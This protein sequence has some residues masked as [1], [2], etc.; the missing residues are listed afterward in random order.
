M[1]SPEFGWYH[2][3]GAREIFRGAASGTAGRADNRDADLVPHREEDCILT[4][5]KRPDPL[6]RPSS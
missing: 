6:F 5:Q 4:A 3:D 1:V 2:Y